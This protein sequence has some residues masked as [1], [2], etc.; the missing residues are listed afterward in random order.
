[1]RIILAS[2]SPRRRELLAQMGM[3]FEVCPSQGEEKITEVLPERAVMELAQQKAA[4]IA[5]KTEGN[6]WILGADTVVVYDQKIL[7][8]PKDAEDAKR[9][10]CMLQDKKHQVYTGVTLIRIKKESGH[11]YQES[12]TFSEGTDVSFYPMTEREICDYIATGEPMDKAGAYG[13]QG[14]AAIFVK[15][16]RGDYNNVVGLPIARLYQELKSW[17]EKK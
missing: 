4:E 13:I 2:A 16:I 10:L 11:F 12:R 7:G 17:K 14:K 1:M 15:G 8:K 3:E 9:M 6:A 5:V